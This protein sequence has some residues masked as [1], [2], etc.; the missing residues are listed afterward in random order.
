M[1]L[2]P[3][4]PTEVLE[5]QYDGET[6][7]LRLELWRR[8]TDEYNRLDT[9]ELCRILIETFETHDWLIPMTSLDDIVRSS[10]MSI[11]EERGGEDLSKFLDTL[12][13]EEEKGIA[14]VDN[15]AFIRRFID[16]FTPATLFGTEGP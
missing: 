7:G 5:E 10:V 14:T 9:S 3:F 12:A 2:I 15:E 1:T 13:E 4:L 8:Y 11:L 6:F 16:W